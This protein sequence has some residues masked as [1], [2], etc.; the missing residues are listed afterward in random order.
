MTREPE[1]EEVELDPGTIPTSE[2]HLNN[3]P[4]VITDAEHFTK[5]LS[6]F[7]T[8]PDKLPH[9]NDW[10]VRALTDMSYLFLG[11]DESYAFNEPLDKWDVSNVTNMAHMFNHCTMFNQPLNNWDTRN[12]VDMSGMFRDCVSFNQPLDKWDVGR[13]EYMNDMF[14]ECI[15]FNRPLNDWNVENVTM[16]TGM[17]D[18]CIMFNQPLDK[19]NMGKVD[20]I[21][22]MFFECRRFNQPLGMWDVGKA[23]SF[24]E[25]F[26]GCKKFN[27]PL[28]MWDVGKATSFKEMFLGCTAFNQ[29]L[30][31]WNI[32]SSDIRDLMG[33]FKGSAM[34]LENIPTAIRDAKLEADIHYYIMGHTD[35]EIRP[36]VP[37]K[38]AYLAASSKNATRISVPPATAVT[39]ATAATPK[40]AKSK[41][42]T[43]K[44]HYPRIDLFIVSHGADLY[45]QPLPPEYLDGSVTM[46]NCGG[47]CGTHTLLSDAF[48]ADCK[49]KLTELMVHQNNPNTFEVMEK[50]SVN[51][52][53]PYKA[54]VDAERPKFPRVDTMVPDEYAK[55]RSHFVSSIDNDGHCKLYH[56]QTEKLYKLTVDFLKTSEISIMQMRDIPKTSGLWALTGKN[57]YD[58]Q[59]L[60]YISPAHKP[61]LVQFTTFLK[62]QFQ[63]HHVMY[64]GDI[65]AICRELGFGYINIYDMSCRACD[66][67]P[68][69][70]LLE[71]KA[72]EEDLEKRRASR[73]GGK[74]KKTITR[75]GKRKSTRNPKRILRRTRRKRNQTRRLKIK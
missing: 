42:K 8:E 73:L 32:R 67:V 7:L 37:D 24:K 15:Q 16:M 49:R 13:V 27:Q 12:V 14:S 23:T 47:D 54:F 70:K 36:P 3:G 2:L 69:E 43:V 68:P 31:N 74:G 34:T 51:R 64:L 58:D 62:N 4:L 71:I 20:S 35:V 26:L 57:I 65:I 59:V 18:S 39:S 10:D 5:M 41:T 17:F 1:I 63:T 45:D 30:V 44:V 72:R 33:M 28:G 46:F 22:G 53:V 38:I 6:I 55:N 56:P 52:K 11:L 75:M 25:M 61:D 60:D 50:F 66:D 19:W 9:I 21:A 48:T 40:T 29:S